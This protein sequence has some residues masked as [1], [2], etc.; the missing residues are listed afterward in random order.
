M[1]KAHV[2]PSECASLI[3]EE[4][5]DLPQFFIERTSLYPYLCWLRGDVLIIGN[6][7]PLDVLDHF[8]GDDE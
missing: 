8:Q 4:V 3:S 5:L 1:L 2:I 6:A 7:R